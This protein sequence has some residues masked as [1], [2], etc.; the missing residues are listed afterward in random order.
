MDRKEFMIR[1]L[2]FSDFHLNGYHV[3]ESKNVLSYMM[4]A[5][6]EIKKD[7]NIDLVL[8]SG[9][10]LEQGGV[11]FGVDKDL[12]EGF[13]KFHE[14]VITPLMECLGLPES[15]FI[16]TPGNHDID[17][18]ADDD[19][20][21]DGLEN[22][23]GSLAEI[24]SLSKDP[25]IF[26]WTSRIDAFKNFEREY[27]A[28][29]RDLNYKNS[30]F[31]STFELEI[32][33][34]KVGIASL[35]TVWRCGYNDA[36]KIVLGLNQ[37]TEQCKPLA[38]KQLRIAL[39]HYPISFLKEIERY[40]VTRKCAN[41]FDLFFCGHSHSGFTDF[42]IPERN[43]FF[44]EINGSGS[45]VSNVYE[46]KDKHKNSFQIVD[47]IPNVRYAIHT[48]KQVYFQEFELDRNAEA[49]KKNE[50]DVPKDPKMLQALFEEQQAELEKRKEDLFKVKIGPFE[51]LQDF[52]N[53]PNN[54]I[55]STEFVSCAQIDNIIQ[56]LLLDSGN[57]RLM[58]LSGMGKTR[59]IMEAFKNTE[60]VY[61][62]PS[63]DCIKGMACLLKECKPNIVII[64]NCNASSMHAAEKCIEEYG[65]RARLI[66][67]YNVLTPEEK[68]TGGKLYEL[69]YSI[70][71]D[72]VDKM[73]DNANI[74][75]QEQLISQAIKNRSGNI[76]YMAILLIDA[77]KKKGNLSIDN[78]DKVL[79]EI[80]QGKK[81]LDEQSK[82]VLRAI[83]LF[84][85]LGKDH[86]VKDEYD[87]VTHSCKI[88]H[89][90][91]RQDIV[92]AG[93]ADTIRDFEN[94][95]LI[96]HEGSCIRIRPRPLAEWLTESWLQKNKEFAP[97]IEDINQQEDDLK[98]RLFRALSN[99]IKLMTSSKFAPQI[100]DELN[101]PDTGSFHDERIA[102]SKAGSQLFL[103]MGVVSP[104]MVA[105]NL[106]SLLQ[107][108]SFDWLRKELDSDARRNLV[109]ALENICHSEEAFMD[110]AKCLARLAVAENE[111][112][113]NNA[114]GLFVQLFHIYLPGTKA[115]LKQ[116]F[117]L[118]QELRN[119]ECY[120]P[121]IM[122]ALDNAFMSG[123][124]NRSNTC[125]IDDDNADYLPSGQDILFYWKDCAAIF[126]AILERN[127][128]LLPAAKKILVR[129]VTGLAHLE[130]KNILF[131]LLDF[132][133]EKCNYD[134]IEVRNA[135]S[136]YLNKWF[137]GTDILRQEYQEM[138]DKFTPKNF[139][140]SLTAF[141]EDHH[142]NIGE[143]YSVFAKSMEERLMPLAE[144]FLNDKV[145]EKDDL[146]K[147]LADRNLDNVWFI[148][149]LSILIKNRPIINDVFKAILCALSS[150]PKDYEEN[151]IPN[152]ISFIGDTDIVKDFVKDIGRA[153]YYRLSA[154]ILG[155]LD[156]KERPYLT[157]LIAG[158]HNGIYDDECIL[159]YLRRYNYQ[160]INDV[161]DIFHT[162]QKDG[163]DE[164][165]VC[166]PFLL[167]HVW[168]INKEEL[169]KFNHI[170]DYKEILLAFDFKD[171][172]NSLNRKIVSNIEDL[173]RFT[174]DKDLVL[175]FHQKI[176][177]VLVSLDYA[178]NPFDNIY[179]DLL[180]K[181]QDVILDDLLKH[182]GSSDLLLAYRISLYLN[183]GSG[184]GTGKGPLFQ[185]DE[186]KLKAACLKNPENLPARLAHLCPVYEFSSEG[187]KNSFSGFFLWLCDN[188]GDQKRMLEEF[189]ANMGT[190][191]WCGVDGFSD[192]IAQQIPCI[193]PLLNHNN[194][195]VREWA[196]KQLE[197]VKN[198]VIREKG[199]EAY[200]T[201][202][203]G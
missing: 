135:L 98:R 3:E 177:Q 117:S 22:R 202:I 85:P 187:R 20:I 186:E 80:L 76:P 113:S 39:T 185:C 82:D 151:F 161:F 83:S 59:I 27:Y 184:L 121:L 148:K 107:A 81:E 89:I 86:G 181:Y 77:F 152:L 4:K 128:T 18:K 21:D 67:V 29:F 70:T 65:S 203:R 90:K 91:Q 102:F 93:F 88:H 140:D 163:I 79:S 100:F 64:D 53:R 179:F 105:K 168:L 165:R 125:G 15:R 99:R 145:Y 131:D 58:A 31:A 25:R 8:F 172:S 170:E 62:S 190:F 143:D 136:Q 51:K 74:P 119:D 196:E 69:D 178:N 122:K 87:Y 147:L 150:F 180:P 26:R 38:D 132:L 130:T 44:W 192:F 134:W 188:F 43:K 60:N 36:H 133:G 32:N 139:F 55:M 141:R 71:K 124:F 154:S 198:E 115:N 137:K 197:A 19:I 1:I 157:L 23:C 57:S 109:W 75:Q 127:E 41:A 123:P 144:E 42:H 49:D 47:C 126:K 176:M 162:L 120:L 96:E 146:V 166:Y 56:S 169:Q 9:D 164:K 34:V 149:D 182:L 45:L 37:I 191:S 129:R 2:H 195:T 11:G 201:M 193:K 111:D 28:P 10:M 33:G 50:F 7:H 158:Y 106:N 156:N 68:S 17:R 159:Q 138:L 95:Q 13:E 12:K 183:L 103:S 104:V 189:G 30:R 5:L 194:Q 61:Y 35:N 6:A 72:V 24:I 200:E 92:D 155:V 78:P 171:S 46:E 97:V 108:K 101:N 54:S 66:T 84:E 63:A 14:V 48:Y 153:G 73:I 94:R 160:S 52:M 142:F 167:N 199:N 112:F 174:D 118:L 175:C 110:A 40:D 116:R 114:T 173:I 16:F